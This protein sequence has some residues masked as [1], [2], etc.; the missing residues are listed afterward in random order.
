MASL[1]TDNI[2]KIEVCPTNGM[3][4]EEMIEHFQKDGEKYERTGIW[5]YAKYTAELE[6]DVCIGN[7]EQCKAWK[8]STEKE[9]YVRD[10][11]TFFNRLAFDLSYLFAY[12]LLSL[13]ITIAVGYF[14]DNNFRIGIFLSLL[15]AMFIH[16]LVHDRTDR[17]FEK[18]LGQ[19]YDKNQNYTKTDE[20]IKEKKEN[21]T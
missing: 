10:N 17:S 16:W 21:L 1:Q 20:N 8:L 9:L 5:P 4:K 11:K 3:K 18:W 13:P 2:H 15:F 6:P 19:K 14:I 12:F 7:C